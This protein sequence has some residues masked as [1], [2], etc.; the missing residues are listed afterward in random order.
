M[1]TPGAPAIRV[2]VA[3]SGTVAVSPGLVGP[4]GGGVRLDG[5]VASYADLPTDLGVEDAGASYATQDDGLLYVWSG[6]AWPPAGAGSQF[7]GDKG[8]RGTGVESV[9]VAGSDLSFGLS[10]GT[11]R[12]VTVPALVDASA[13]AADAVGAA[14]LAVSARSA[15]ELAR[16]GAVAAADRAEG[17]A[18]GVAADAA[19]AVNAAGRAEVAAD[20]AD[21]SADAA[22]VSAGEAAASAEATAVDAAEV[23]EA[24]EYVSG[25]H[26]QLS[27]G[28]ATAV[29]LEEITNNAF[30][31]LA[32]TRDARDAAAGHADR[33]EVAADGV[34]QV[35][36]DAAGVLAGEIA[37]DLA[38]SQAARS[39][40]EAA[41]DQAV[42]AAEA[43]VAK[44]QQKVTALEARVKALESQAVKSS[45]IRT[46][47]KGTGKST[48][49]LYI[50]V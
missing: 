1:S 44:L 36:S 15:A 3:H 14:D 39:G 16:D 11:S 25:V 32:Q 5:A 28:G 42:D 27:P 7:R 8:D 4:Q 13:A 9:S 40:A 12:R 33:A 45:T 48:S 46:I 38:A 21:A 37:D 30:S 10:D 18:D 19:A 20:A 23:G 43:A 26:E 34:D 6:T 22:G 29:M 47:A 17:A 41:R 49:T 35:V 2:E 31:A 24:R 50:E